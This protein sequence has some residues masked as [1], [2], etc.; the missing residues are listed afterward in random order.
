MTKTTFGLVVAI[1]LLAMLVTAGPVLV[2]LA[3]AAVPLVV[4]TGLVVGLLR[5][6][7]LVTE[8]YR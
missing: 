4:A 5:F 1:V 7:W 3:E 8:R 2:A 6:V